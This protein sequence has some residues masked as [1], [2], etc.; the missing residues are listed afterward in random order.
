MPT[1]HEYC[2]ISYQKDSY[3][4]PLPDKL[5]PDFHAFVK[6]ELVAA[7]AQDVSNRDIQV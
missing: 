3:S 2:T 5:P 4:V 1:R 6:E 7:G